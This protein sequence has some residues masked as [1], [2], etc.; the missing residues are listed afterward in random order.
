MIKIWQPRYK[1]KIVL[2]ATYKIVS[3]KDTEFEITEG[4][5]KGKYIAPWS[6]VKDCAIENKPTRSGH[7]M[8]FTVVP[9]KDLVKVD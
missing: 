8:D 7:K 4:Y 9:I 6:V 3:G 5:Y 1:D 2:I